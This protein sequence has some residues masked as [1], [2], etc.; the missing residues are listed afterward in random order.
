M[1]T[2]LFFLLFLIA[3]ILEGTLTIIPLFLSVLLVAYIIKDKNWIFP[4]AFFCGIFL[5][6]LSLRTIGESSTFFVIFIFTVALYEHKFEVQSI[7]FVFFASFLGSLFYSFLFVKSGIFWESLASA[8]ISVI[9]FLLL[10]K[11]SA[12][13]DDIK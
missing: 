6:I 2:L 9:I 3:I 12:L 7:P 10:Y 4:V 8:L 13:R 11:R 1:S 5:D